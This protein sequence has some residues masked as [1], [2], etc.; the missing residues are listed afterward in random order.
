MSQTSKRA[1]NGLGLTM[2]QTSKGPT[3]AKN[4]R[5]CLRPKIKRESTHLGDY[6]IGTL[7][8]IGAWRVWHGPF[9]LLLLPFFFFFFFFK[10]L[11][12]VW[13]ETS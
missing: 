3:M 8:L 2:N 12:L 1:D 5:G 9:G 6:Q 11:D 10:N 4:K 13:V 7:N